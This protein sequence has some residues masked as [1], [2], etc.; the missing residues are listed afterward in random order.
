MGKLRMIIMDRGDKGNVSG[1]IV[2]ANPP[3]Q[4]GNSVPRQFLKVE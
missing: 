3:L 4:P 2:F 1:R